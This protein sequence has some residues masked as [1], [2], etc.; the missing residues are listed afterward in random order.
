MIF[1]KKKVL[2]KTKQKQY[3]P[4][5]VNVVEC[6]KFLDISAPTPQRLWHIINQTNNIPG[7]KTCGEQVAW[8]HRYKHYKTYCGNPQCPNVD[9]DVIRQK[10]QKNNYK[11]AASKRAM[12]NLK[13]YGHTNF[14]ASAVGKEESSKKRKPL[15]KQQVDERNNLS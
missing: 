10:K 11:L 5:L 4:I 13:K 8:D 6:T 2:I 9:P 7:C 15:T 1:L 3:R 12:T 14:L